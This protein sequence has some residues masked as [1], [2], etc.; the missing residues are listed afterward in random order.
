FLALAVVV[1]RGRGV[2]DGRGRCGRRCG[3]RSRRRDRVR[4]LQIAAARRQTEHDERDD[5]R[6]DERRDDRTPRAARLTGCGRRY[7]G[8]RGDSRNGNR[9][10]GVAG[11]REDRGR[12]V[13][14]VR[15]RERPRVG[16]G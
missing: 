15:G 1:V 12:I 16:D 13:V 2:G 14:L 7:R 9:G 10:C 6:G 3:G 4:R 8:G 5:R 11:Y